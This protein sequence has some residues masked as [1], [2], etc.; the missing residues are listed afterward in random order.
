[1]P[2]QKGKVPGQKGK[3]PSISHLVKF[4]DFKRFITIIQPL[5]CV[6]ICFVFFER[7]AVYLCGFF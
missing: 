5:L 2:G 1:M 3:V 7:L 4:L 6:S